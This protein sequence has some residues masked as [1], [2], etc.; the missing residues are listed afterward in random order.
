MLTYQTMINRKRYEE[1]FHSVE[2]LFEK[3]FDLE[4]KR[5]TLCFFFFL[6]SITADPKWNDWLAK[7]GYRK[8]NFKENLL[9]E[10]L[11]VKEIWIFCF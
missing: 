11:F 4:K 8:L 7:N 10:E 2:F 5:N 6:N 3:S 9:V 1:E